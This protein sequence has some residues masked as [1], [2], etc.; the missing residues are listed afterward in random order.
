MMRYHF[1][2]CHWQV[3]TGRDEVLAAVGT[4]DMSWEAGNTGSDPLLE[5][6]THCREF[7]RLLQCCCLMVPPTRGTVHTEIDRMV[8]SMGMEHTRAVA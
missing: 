3:A 8:D 6:D 2:R 4:E 5:L 1:R 7:V